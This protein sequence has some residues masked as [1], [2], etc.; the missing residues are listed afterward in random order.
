MDGCEKSENSIHG[1]KILL[2][3]GEKEKEPRKEEQER[4]CPRCQGRGISKGG[5]KQP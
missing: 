3:T 1:E 2:V 5:G 4:Q